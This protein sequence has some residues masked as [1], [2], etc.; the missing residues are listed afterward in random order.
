MN[1]TAGDSAYFDNTLTAAVNGETAVVAKN[2]DGTATV[3]YTFVATEEE[4]D[5]GK[6]AVKPDAGKD[7]VI[8]TGDTSLTM[9]PFMLMFASALCC[10]VLLMTNSRI[11]KRNEKNKS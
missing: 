6:P 1:F 4:K 7:D 3:S 8:K 11:G 2:T 5:N 9:I 10:M